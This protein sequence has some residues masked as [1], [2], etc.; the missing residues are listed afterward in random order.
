MRM[1][2]G[3]QLL[4]A[5]RTKLETVWHNGGT[6]GYRSFLGFA[7]SISSAAVVLSANQRTVDPIGFEL[8]QR[9]D[10]SRAHSADPV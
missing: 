5:G 8:L 1:G 3:W 2:L 10:A 4:P 9:I 7:P 6:G